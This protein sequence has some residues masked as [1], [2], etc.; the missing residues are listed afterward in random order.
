MKQET[1]APSSTSEN[2]G[3][4]SGSG[5]ER[6]SFLKGLGI[7]GAVVAGGSLVSAAAEAAAQKT[8]VITSGDVAI[9]R[10]LAA[11][12][13]LEADLWQQYAE[14]GGLSSGT[15]NPYQMA[16]QLLDGDGSQYIQSNTIDEASHAAFLNAYLESIGAEP[17]DLDAFRTL[18]SS[19]AT[20]AQQIG[21]LTNLMNNTVDTSW[22]NY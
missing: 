21:R 5:V 15:Q 9:L 8:G 1:L 3:S 18:P 12:E 14:L 4:S 11:A 16:L 6:R 19:Q 2:A 13:L 22:G 10:F 20:G 17:V 7:A